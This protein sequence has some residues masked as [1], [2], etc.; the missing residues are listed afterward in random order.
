[1]TMR[2]SLPRA[3]VAALLLVAALAAGRVARAEPYPSRPVTIIVPYAPGGTTD[4]MARLIGQKLE[5]K[6]G[7]PF[8][9]ENRPGAGTVIAASFLAKAPSDGHTLMLATSTT[10]AINV[11]VH[12]SLPYDP[13][14]DLTPVALIAGVPFLLVV[15]PAI[16]VRSVADLVAF[17]KAERSLAYA[18]NGHG[19]AGHLYAELLKTMLG[20]EMTHVPYKGLAPALNDVAAGQVPLMFGDFATALPLVRSGKLRALG[21]S[22]RERVA[23][24]TDI[25]PLAEAGVPGY[26]ASSWQMVVAPPRL[27]P[28]ILDRLNTEL[29]AILAEPDVARDFAAR[30]IIP[31]ASPSPDALKTFVQT[32][33]A[34]WG[35]VVGKAGATGIE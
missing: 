9:A 19:G 27:P 13:T 23:S 14:R 11:S 22:T 30:G 16:P 35:E 2:A 15:N 34:R 18:S 21:V 4:A 7:K 33:I 28:D 32:E 31:L 24:A 1:M 12:K 6:L 17:A 25:P 26:E 20:I 29:R 3:L 10:M 5:Q 8:V